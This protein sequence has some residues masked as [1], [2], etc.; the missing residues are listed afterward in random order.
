M[1]G[2]GHVTPNA[3]GSKA[4][5]GGP[6]LCTVCALELARLQQP[7]RDDITAALVERAERAEANVEAMRND[8][9][10]NKAYREVAE[11]AAAL[12]RLFPSWVNV[13]P[14]EPDWP[15]LYA[16]LPSGQVSWHFS[17]DDLDLIAD[18]Q[19]VGPPWDGHTRED[20]SARLAALRPVGEIA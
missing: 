9:S 7:L 15:V 2:H 12:A 11:M 3:D 1:N 19:R 10:K 4:R 18:I 8:S 20:R 13:D 6:A 14:A 16:Q 17:R 5:C